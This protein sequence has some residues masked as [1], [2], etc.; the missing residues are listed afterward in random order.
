MTYVVSIEAEDKANCYC[1]FSGENGRQLLLLQSVGQAGRVSNTHIR[2]YISGS[3][4]VCTQYYPI[5]T[6]IPSAACDL[7]PQSAK[8][9]FRLGFCIY[10]YSMVLR[11]RFDLFLWGEPYHSLSFLVNYTTK[12]YL[13][14][15][16]GLS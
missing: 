6:K 8:T 4:L 2:V 5:H 3:D 9:K 12:E 7:V 1:C 15:Y 14:R 11:K 13:F 16:R 10:P